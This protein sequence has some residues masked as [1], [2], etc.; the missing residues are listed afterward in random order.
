MKIRI[1]LFL[2]IAL[3]TVTN[4]LYAQ[5]TAFTY[6]GHLNDGVNPANGSYDQTFA[7]FNVVSGAGQVG[8]TFTNPATAVSNGQFT[9]TLDFGPGIFTGPDR[10]L[11]IGVRTNGNG[12]FTLLAPRQ[13]I[14]PVPY[15]IMANNASNLLGVL[16][17]AQLGAGTA[18]INISGAAASFT[19]SLAG[20]VTGTQSATVVN[21]VGGVTAANVASG[22]NAANAAT[23]ANTAN[24]IVK[25]DVSGNFYAGSV[26]LAGNLNLPAT[27]ANSG[28]IKSGA[29]TLLHTFGSANIFVGVGAGNLTTTGS[30]NTGT[31]FNALNHD[32]SGLGNTA[33]GQTAL[34]NNTTGGDNVAIGFSALLLN[35]D[36]D[37]NTAIGY[38]ALTSNT[39]GSYNTADGMSALYAN[40]S[41]YNNTA[42]GYAAL[43]SNIDGHDNTANGYQA[44]YNNTNG[45]YNT[46][47]GEDALLA[48]KSGSY[49]AADGY[50]ALG[51]NTSGNNNIALGYQAGLNISTGSSNIDIGNF[52]VSTDTN[53]IRV[54]S[55]QARTFIAGI[56]GAN[57][58]PGSPVY[59]NS[60]G[61]LGTVN[62]SPG[63]AQNIQ[64]MADA[65]DVLLA[66][67][68]VTF[69]YKT[70]LDPT[71]TPQFGLLAE[72]VEKIDP[73]LVARDDK[74]QIFSVRYE[75]V[76]A[77]LLNE[78]IKQHRK[79]EEQNTEI[80]T[81]KQ[82][83]EALEKLIQNRKPN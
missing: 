19:G 11:E 81:L 39:N 77:M 25:R 31:G 38:Q 52:G 75:A 23:S 1:L 79:V 17:A 66:L 74:K 51:L 18:A 32:T 78:F 59:A 62:S 72:D 16:P 20:N 45:F 33:N 61:Q 40:T 28:L 5:G 54:G 26:T 55:S 67:K 37:Y 27:T 82:R 41:G 83:L 35:L 47:N 80:E 12:A 68:P 65:S 58:F 21:T 56:F 34:F 73:D 48:N 60:N 2:T 10:W 57:I 13:P 49:N 8:N 15:A 30:G 71:A 63:L 46:A 14:T 53:I 24:T 3:L 9:V 36:G 70:E 43:Y 7:L 76:N 4:S 64:S 50:F 42:N 6:Q 44:L 22:A 69:R 29:T